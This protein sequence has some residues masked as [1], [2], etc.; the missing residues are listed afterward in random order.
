MI[1][2]NNCAC[3]NIKRRLRELS[4]AVYETVLYLDGHPDCPEALEHYNALIAELE[5]VTDEYEEKYGPLTIY[6]NSCDTWK[7]V[8]SPWPWESEAN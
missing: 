2:M 4:F 7:W 3:R 8:S 5:Q 6:S 1:N